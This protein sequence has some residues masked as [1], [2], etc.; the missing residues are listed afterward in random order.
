MF[1]TLSDRKI[2]YEVKGSGEA[3]VLLH[4]WGGS[5]QSFR[6]IFNRLSLKNRIYA[7]DLPGFGRSDP[8]AP[9]WSTPEYAKIVIEIL[10][11]LEICRPHL[12]GHSF[13]GRIALY[14]AAF[15]PERVGKL[16][17]VDS[18]G[19]KPKRGW[20]TRLRV[21]GFKVMKYTLALLGSWGDKHLQRLYQKI[22]SADYRAAG[23]LRSVLVKVVNEDLTPILGK[24]VCRTLLIWGELDSDTPLT[25]GQL[26]HSRLPSSR[27]V[28]IKGAGHYSYLKDPEFFCDTVTQFLH[29][30]CSD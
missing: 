28:V 24:I 25:D 3:T 8:P 18:A 15:Y 26:M 19:I 5:V 6:P 7:I 21:G 12:L 13:G 16:I 23:A 9:E 30:P 10:D 14:L 27:L 17:L 20:R 4:G 2:Y 11:S 22:G 1:V 29:P